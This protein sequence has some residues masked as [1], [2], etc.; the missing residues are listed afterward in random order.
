MLDI[1]L[2]SLFVP[3]AKL[4]FRLNFIGSKSILDIPLYS[5]FVPAKA[6]KQPPI[7]SMA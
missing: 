6:F 2:Y 4:A 7:V 5:L 3:E 1:C